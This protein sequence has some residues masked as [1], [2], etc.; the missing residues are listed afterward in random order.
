MFCFAETRKSDLG[1]VYFVRCLH[2][3][4]VSLHIY[5]VLMVGVFIQRAP[6]VFP[7]LIVI[8]AWA[9]VFYS[10]KEFA[11]YK[12]EKLPYP[13]LRSDK[14]ISCKVYETKGTYVQPELLD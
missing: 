5:M 7:V 9:Y 13:E 8:L 2:N 3:C 12:W 1:G 10:Q 6:N 4:Y 11:N 14:K